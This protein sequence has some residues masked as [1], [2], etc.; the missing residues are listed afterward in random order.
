MTTI[1]KFTLKHGLSV[2][3]VLMDGLDIMQHGV[4]DKFFDQVWDMLKDG[5]V[6]FA[7]NGSTPMMTKDGKNRQWIIQF[8][9]DHPKADLWRKNLD[10]DK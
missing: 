9:S 1:E 5:G 4:N 2:S 7:P 8:D 3:M 6:Y 10:T